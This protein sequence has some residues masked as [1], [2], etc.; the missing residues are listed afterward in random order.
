MIPV[1][2]KIHESHV[3]LFVVE[4]SVSPSDCTTADGTALASLLMWGQ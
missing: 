4:K 3:M 1:K 2:N